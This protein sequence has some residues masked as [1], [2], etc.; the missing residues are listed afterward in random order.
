MVVG[1]FVDDYTID[2]QYRNDLGALLQFNISITYLSK[3]EQ[4]EKSKLIRLD[5]ISI[6]PTRCSNFQ[7]NQLN[8]ED[9]D[10]QWIKQ[11]FIQSSHIGEKT[12]TIGENI[13]LLIQ[14]YLN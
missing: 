11:K 10:W 7:V 2:Q 12:W 6:F 4:N 8:F 1:I 5:S 14:N 3:E 9:E 13:Q